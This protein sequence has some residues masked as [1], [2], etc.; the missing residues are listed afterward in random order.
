MKKFTI[1]TLLILI[2]FTFCFSNESVIEPS[3]THEI[4]EI[5][6]GNIKEL[7]VSQLNSNQFLSGGLLL[8]LLASLGF[9]LKKFPVWVYNRIMRLITFHLYVDENDM[10]YIYFNRWLKEN[11]EQKLRNSQI[12]L[13][14]KRVDSDNANSPTDKKTTKKKTT[15]YLKPKNDSF[16]IWYKGTPLKVSKGQDKLESA[17]DFY[18]MIYNHYSISGFFA[19]K[20]IQK[21]IDDVLAYTDEEKEISSEYEIYVNS[22]YSD[23]CYT[24]SKKGRNVDSVVLNK[25]TKDSIFNGLDTFIESEEWYIERGIPYQYNMLIHGSPGSGKSSIISAIANKYLYNVYYMTLSGD[26]L[27]DTTLMLLFSRIPEHSILVMEDIDSIFRGRENI[28]KSKI[29]FSGF[30]NSLDGIISKHN[31]ISIMTTNH[32]ETLDTALIRSGRIDNMVE[33]CYPEIKEIQ[34]Y[35]KRFFNE[36]LKL[37]HMDKQNISMAKIQ[38]ICM[39]HI[40]N[41]ENAHNEIVSLLTV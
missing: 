26:Q 12:Y 37:Q 24:F 16:I 20:T 25:K 21:L 38:E 3:I 40:N 19:K 35:F 13:S 7:V 14:E 36:E 18:S 17:K 11:Y 28:S 5:S 23:W 32:P 41:Y 22:N 8:G 10:F 9:Y 31:F 6:N 15:Y 2:T 4:E 30:I 1:F 34:T 33:I 27:S 29:T 39:L